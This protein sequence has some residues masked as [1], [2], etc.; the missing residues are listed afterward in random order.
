MDAYRRP[1]IEPVVFRDDD[2]A[3]IAYG[4]RWGSESPPSDSYSV[5]SNAERFRP[6]RRIADALIAAL[7][8]EYVVTVEDDLS[9]ASDL[10]HDRDDVV[11]A[12]RITP[13]DP[14][15][16]SLTF[17]CTSFPS[18]IVHAGLLHDFLYPVCGCDACDETWEH[19]ADELEWDVRAVIDG[20]YSERAG[21][22]GEGFRLVGSDGSRSG[23]GGESSTQ[24]R[25]DAAARTLSTI[26]AWSAWQKRR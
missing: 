4:E 11:R 16:A 15:S 10:M 12:V 14:T 26:D 1:A 21:A 3:A 20:G 25:T 18:V 22:N 7:A 8:D 9:A 5:V 6:L 19:L 17:V 23:S 2:G 13:D 24:A